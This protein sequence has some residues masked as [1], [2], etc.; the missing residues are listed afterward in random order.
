MQLTSPRV[1]FDLKKIIIINIIPKW[2]CSSFIY[3]ILDVFYIFALGAETESVVDGIPMNKLSI[4]IEESESLFEYDEDQ[5][6]VGMISE[7]RSFSTLPTLCIS[8]IEIKINLNFGFNTSLWCCKRFYESLRSVRKKCR[9]TS[10]DLI[11]C[12]RPGLGREGLIPVGIIHL[13]LKQFFP[14]DFHF[15]RPAYQGLRNV[16]FL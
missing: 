2:K 15:L 1:Q 6:V 9:K 8:G 11:F 7:V 10:F 3:Y 16:G 13:V 14:N 12:L 5:L 4:N